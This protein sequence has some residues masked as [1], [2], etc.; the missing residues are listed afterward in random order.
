MATTKKEVIYT[1]P[2]GTEKEIRKAQAK[3]Q[4]LYDKF[5]SVQVCPNGISEVRIIATDKIK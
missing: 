2:Y 5:N 1:M 3:R 4:R